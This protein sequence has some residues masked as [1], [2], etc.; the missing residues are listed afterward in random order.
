MYVGPPHCW[1]KVYAGCITCC[2][3]VSHG[4]YADGTDRQMDTRPLR[5]IAVSAV[6]AAS[7]ING[8][9]ERLH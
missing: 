6:D 3:L 4:E 9:R 8:V 2:P 1:A 7:V 5:Y